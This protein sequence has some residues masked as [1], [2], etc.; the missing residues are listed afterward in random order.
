MLGLGGSRICRCRFEV[1]AFSEEE[2]VRFGVPFLG[3]A[4]RLLGASIRYCSL[5]RMRRASRWRVRFVHTVSTRPALSNQECMKTRWGL[6]KSISSRAPFSKP[7]NLSVA[8]ITGIVGQTRL[9]I[10]FADRQT[11]A[12][13]TPMN[14]RSDALAGAAEWIGAVEKL[15]QRTEG[16]VANSR[17]HRGLAQRFQRRR[18]TLR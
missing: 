15:A 11:I 1:I 13:T 10:E 12:G 17:R 5:S 9:T 6:S 8:A 14:L 18:R 2:G 4:A 3:R 7:E 16:L